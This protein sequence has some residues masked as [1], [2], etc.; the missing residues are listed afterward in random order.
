MSNL[1]SIVEMYLSESLEDPKKEISSAMNMLA[2]SLVSSVGAPVV[3]H[4]DRLL[5]AIPVSVCPYWYQGALLMSMISVA[6]G[7]WCFSTMKILNNI[8]VTCPGKDAF[9][10]NEKMLEN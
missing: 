8:L 3:A 7:K 5:N 6:E 1:R 10:I 4:V 2:L 9:N